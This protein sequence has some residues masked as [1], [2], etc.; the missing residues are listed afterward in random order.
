FNAKLLIALALGWLALLVLLPLGTVFGQALSQGLSRALA[1]FQDPDAW[2]AIRLTLLVAAIS[3]PLNAIFGLAAARAI[4]K[5]E[6][7]GRG[8]LMPLI[9]LP[10]SMSPVVSGLVWVLLFGAQ[11]WF[12]PVLDKLGVHVIF[13]VTGLVLATILVTMP[14]IARELIPLM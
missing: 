3:V 13:T 5:F 6:F 7:H 10:L 14:Y 1:T 11:G 8:V 4:G 9:D 12:A 2:A